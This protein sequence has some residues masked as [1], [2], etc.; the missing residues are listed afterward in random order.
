MAHGGR[1]GRGRV[2]VEPLLDRPDNMLMFPARDAAMLAFVTAIL[3]RA[4]LASCSSRLHEIVSQGV[5]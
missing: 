4:G 2:F 5:V 3:D 1:T